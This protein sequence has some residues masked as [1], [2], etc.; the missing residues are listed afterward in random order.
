M[1]RKLITKI[2]CIILALLMV[3]G[4]VVMAINLIG[5]L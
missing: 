3:S 1:N 5:N 4:V 2:I